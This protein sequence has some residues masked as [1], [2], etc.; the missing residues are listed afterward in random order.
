ASTE[1]FTYDGLNRLKEARLNYAG[2]TKN[3]YYCYDALG[4]MTT[5][6]SATACSSSQGHFSYGNAAR[7]KG[8]AGVHALYKDTRTGKVFTY[9]NNGNMTN[10]GSRY[11]TYS[12]FDKVT[13]IRQAGNMAVNFRYG[14]GHNRYYRK[15]TYLAGQDAAAGKENSETYYYG[16][17]EHI[18]KESAEVYQ[19]TVGNIL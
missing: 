12:G 4:N 15:D 17:F 14:A 10:D 1:H 5:K 18:R 11:L 13:H 6:G 9:D 7:S 19:Y 2:L 3:T 8:N 16:A